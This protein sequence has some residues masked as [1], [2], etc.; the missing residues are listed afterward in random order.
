M[1]DFLLE[2]LR[3]FKTSQVSALINSKNSSRFQRLVYL[4]L[5]F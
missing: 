5:F 3:C 4:Q 2:N 1:R